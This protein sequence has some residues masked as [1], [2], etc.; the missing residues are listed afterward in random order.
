MKIKL[1]GILIAAVMILAACSPQTNSPAATSAPAAAGNEIKISGFAFNPA[2]ITIKVGDT[3]TWTN[4]D[5]TAHTVVADDKSWKSDNLEN[6][7]SFS[8]TFDT[9]GTF[10]YICSIHP[11]M[12]GTVIVQ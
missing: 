2:T 1:T 5:G 6:G 7:A 9:A 10:S 4:E 11:T 8:H 12:K 3:V